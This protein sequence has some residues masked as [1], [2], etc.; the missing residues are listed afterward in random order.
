MR[1]VRC[2]SALART[3]VIPPSDAVAEPALRKALRGDLDTIVLKALKESPEERYP[4]ANA[5][6]DDLRR[7]LSGR[8]V[9]ARPDSSWYRLSKFARRHGLAVA[10][11]SIA[12]LAVLTGAGVA[13]W[14]WRVALGEQR[15]A[16]EVKEFVASIF[17]DADLDA[18]ESRLM[19]VVELLKQATGR[20]ATLEAPP[21]VRVELL[22]LVGTGLLSL[23]DTDALEAV[24]TRA[25]DEAA[26]GLEPADPLTLRARILMAWTH[27]YRGKSKEMLEELET[28]SALMQRD[29]DT[30]AGDLATIWRMRAD[31]AIDA[32]DYPKAEAAAKEAVARAEAAYGSRDQHTLLAVS[33][34][35]TAYRFNGRPADALQNAERAQQLATELFRNNPR[36]PY[37][38]HARAEY[39]S[40]ARRSRPVERRDRSVEAGARGRDSALWTERA[41]RRLPPPEPRRL[42]V[43]A[44]TDSRGRVDQRQGAGHPGA[45][46][47][48]GID[49]R[50]GR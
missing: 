5:F 35:T 18:T 31:H 12:L 16:E 24:A 6:G 28:T 48:T 21:R 8:P 44:R 46:R 39:R 29:P 22:N 41:N 11:A 23:G 25:V 47:A 36:H 13:V 2:E 33:T 26:R 30:F 20:I 45:P 3:D 32:A 50:G 37:A 10:A 7:C 27:N 38:L 15:R 19:S 34:L 1:R 42:R 4:T 43:E 14:Q 49:D 9:A 40:R 17:R